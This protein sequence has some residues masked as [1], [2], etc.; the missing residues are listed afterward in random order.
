VSSFRNGLRCLS[1]LPALGALTACAG[2]PDPEATA[3]SH[4]YAHFQQVGEIRDAVVRGEVGGT[5]SAARWLASHKGDEFP[6]PA[7]QEALEKMQAEGRII[8]AQD[9]ITDVARSV[10]RLGAAC[11]TCH[12]ALN[13]GPHVNVPSLPPIPAAG[14]PPEAHMNRH[15]WASERL[16]EGLIGP[17]EGSWTVGA[18]ALDGPAL[19]FGP[20]SNRPP[21]ADELAAKVHD[22]AV[23]ARQAHTLQERATV[24]GQLLQTCAECHE[25]LGM[26][27]T[28]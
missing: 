4:M 19:D 17:S 8:L 22:L 14:S 13:G 11:G 9:E 21:Q 15:A 16:W 2:G 18:A 28:R 12:V 26:R 3:P 1:L 27:M 7:A 10:G 5:R 6:D 23:S 24:Y 25:I 20:A